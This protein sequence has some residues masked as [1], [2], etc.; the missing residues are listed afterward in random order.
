MQN[1]FMRSSVFKF[2]LV[3]TISVLLQGSVL[4]HFVS[5]SYVPDLL[6][7]VILL[8]A[9][10]MDEVPSLIFAFASGLFQDF[11]GA[12]Y[13]GPHAVGNIVAVYFLLLISKHIYAD[14][15]LSLGLVCFVCVLVKQVA[16]MAMMLSFVDLKLVSYAD[17][18]L[19]ALGVAFVSALISPLVSKSL[20]KAKIKR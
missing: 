19:R 12:R 17:L 3:V 15:S 16:S 18:G 11:T 1:S 5:E 20:F 6:V 8:M 10:R 14:R 9:L 4:N 13:L 2:I 7:V